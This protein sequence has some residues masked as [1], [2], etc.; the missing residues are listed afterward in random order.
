M[1]PRWYS[2]L[3]LTMCLISCGSDRSK[4]SPVEPIGGE[5]P[6]LTISGVYADTLPCADCDGI[7]THL[8]LY[9]DSTFALLERYLGK[10]GDTGKIPGMYGKYAIEPSCTRLSLRGINDKRIV[11]FR[12]V[13]GGLLLLDS[14]GLPF[15][16]TLD[17]VLDRT[18]QLAE[19][20]SSQRLRTQDSK[21]AGQVGVVYN[22]TL[23]NEVLIDEAFLRNA[24]E[25]E[26]AIVA[27]YFTAHESACPAAD[28]PLHKSFGMDDAGLKALVSK[29]LGGNNQVRDIMNAGVKSGDL[30]LIQLRK[31][32][33]GFRATTVI[34]I[35]TGVERR[36]DRFELRDDKLIWTFSEAGKIDRNTTAK[37]TDRPAEYQ[38]GGQQVIRM[39]KLKE[40]PK[41]NSSENKE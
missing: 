17:Y 22:R 36:D 40:N 3:V 33:G 41:R 12:P 24:T 18:D 19:S 2:A 26:K 15:V 4:P 1:A 21:L 34:R 14:Q 30:Q 16:S 10:A 5:N 23:R 20:T 6:Y 38:Q 37:M 13:S 27:W 35:P 8:T 29:W 31:D 25:P 28:C 32:N 7:L 11:Y 9:P 39:E